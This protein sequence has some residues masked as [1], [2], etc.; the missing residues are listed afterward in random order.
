M[1]GRFERAFCLLETPPRDK[2][3]KDERPGLRDLPFTG[4]HFNP[5]TPCMQGEMQL[6]LPNPGDTP[7]GLFLTRAA[8][9]EREREREREKTIDKHIH[10]H[11]AT[12]Q[13]SVVWLVLLCIAGFA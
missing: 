13:I 12:I 7:T 8:Q 10:F 9:H 3:G 11:V 1:S 6:A 2:K 4:A 5:T